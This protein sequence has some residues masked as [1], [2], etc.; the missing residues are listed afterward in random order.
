MQPLGNKTPKLYVKS[1][2]C[3]PFRSIPK[4]ID[5]RLTTFFKAIRSLF[6]KTQ[7]QNNLLPFQRKLLNKLRKQQEVII[8]KTD[9]GLGPCAIEFSQYAQDIMA[10]LSNPLHYQIL[11]EQEANN[12]I[13]QIHCKIHTWISKDR[14]FLDDDAVKY[15]YMTAHLKT[16]KTPMGISTSYTRFTLAG[17]VGDMSAACW[18][19]GKM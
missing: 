13:S 7:G 10:H 3:P 2:W 11:P 6:K 14:K 5:Q 18:Q 17:K 4:E 12:L 19:Q 1:T 8:Y 9:K 16:A 15:I